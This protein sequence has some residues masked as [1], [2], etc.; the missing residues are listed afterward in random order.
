MLQVFNILL[1]PDKE[2]AGRRGHQQWKH[3]N[4]HLI[5]YLS[6]AK[7]RSQKN[8]ASLQHTFTSW[9]RNCREKRTSAMKAKDCKSTAR[10]LGHSPNTAAN[11]MSLHKQRMGNHVHRHIIY[12]HQVKNLLWNGS[13]FRAKHWS[14]NYVNRLKHQHE[15]KRKLFYGH[16][17]T[18]KALNSLVGVSHKVILK[19]CN[20]TIAKCFSPD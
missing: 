10:P 15:L 6:L 11:N 1:H 20:L 19:R 17:C 7:P 18:S 4:C 16:S 3:D 2:T 13:W 9:Q 8:A 5:D 14:T 12:L